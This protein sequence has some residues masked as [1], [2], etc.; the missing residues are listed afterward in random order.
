[1]V[2]KTKIAYLGLLSILIVI[3]QLLLACSGNSTLPSVPTD[4]SESSAIVSTVG[5]GEIGKVN[6]QYIYAN[7]L[8]ELVA[9]S[10]LIVIGQLDKLGAVVN[11]AR[12]PQDTS[13]PSSST[14]GIGQ[15]YTFTVERYLKG[16]SSSPLN[17][18]QG[19]GLI[20]LN[21]A[22][23]SEDN[24]KKAKANSGIP[25]LQ[26]NRKYL[27]FLKPLEGDFAGK[28]F[29]V[30]PI[31][32]WRFVLPDKENAYPETP[33]N[34][35]VS[36]LNS[37][38]TTQ[39][40]NTVEQIASRNP[41]IPPKPTNAPSPTPMVKPNDP[42]NLVKLYNLD[43]AVSITVGI[44]R[45]PA[46]EINDTAKITAVLASLDKPIN[47]AP[48]SSIPANVDAA[49]FRT[50]SFNFSDGKAIKF[51][52]ILKDNI[53]IL[54]VTENARITIPPELLQIFGWN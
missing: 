21:Q 18:I 52:I 48:P 14:F 16:N 49:N 19:E 35:A 20:I 12:N 27:L 37:M 29:Y 7:S 31:M 36:E 45:Q 4:V 13:K 44:P 40:I 24:I 2:R 10:P 54:P 43:K 17:L 32:P 5:E 38:P 11:T 39:L 3:S 8:S 41:T 9:L 33:T 50:L 22:Q 23:A 47:Q 6:V 25:T 46:Q 26:P 30:A 15:T 1:M 42:L 51:E 53:L 34:R 28:D